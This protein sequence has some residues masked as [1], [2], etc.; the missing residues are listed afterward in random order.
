MVDP[1]KHFD[2]RLLSQKADQLRA[3]L[4]QRAVSD[5]FQVNIPESCG[6]TDEKPAQP[7][8]YAYLPLSAHRSQLPA[9]VQ[10]ERPALKKASST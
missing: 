1:A 5:N 7:P 8:K 10:Y 6:E 9:G 3:L 4:P 2:M